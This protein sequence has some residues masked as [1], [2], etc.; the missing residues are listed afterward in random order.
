MYSNFYLAVTF[1]QLEAYGPEHSPQKQFQSINIFA[2][3]NDYTIM[4]IKIEN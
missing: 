1:M 4:S 3:R 2:Q